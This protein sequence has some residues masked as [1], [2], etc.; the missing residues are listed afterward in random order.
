MRIARIRVVVEQPRR[1][2]CQAIPQVVYRCDLRRRAV[3]VDMQKREMLRSDLRQCFRYR[4]NN[5]ADVFPLSEIRAHCL[6]VRC[7]KSAVQLPPVALESTVSF[8][9]DRDVAFIE[10]AECVE[11]IKTSARFAPVEI[12]HDRRT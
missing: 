6:D 1:S 3:Q 8:F 4:S 10:T 11:E 5:D 12:V 2:G 7:V 9:L